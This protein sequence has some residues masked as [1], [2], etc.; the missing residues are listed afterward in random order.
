MGSLNLNPGCT[1]LVELEAD[2][3]RRKYRRNVALYI[4]YLQDHNDD[5][6][7]IV[8]EYMPLYIKHLLA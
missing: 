6:K 5:S 7:A 2:R 4:E 3:R 1:Y 8:S